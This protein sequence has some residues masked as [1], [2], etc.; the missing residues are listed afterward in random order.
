MTVQSVGSVAQLVLENQ[1][2]RK[3]LLKSTLGT[4]FWQPVSFSFVEQ[5]IDP[6]LRASFLH[7]LISFLFPF[8][9]PH[10]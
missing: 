4:K 3:L 8:P 10:D 9:R 2:Y 1:Q 6:N 5:A 7:L